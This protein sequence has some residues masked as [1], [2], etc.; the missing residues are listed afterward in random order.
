MSSFFI[1]TYVL[2]NKYV[3]GDDMSKTTIKIEGRTIDWSVCLF[4]GRSDGALVSR[5]LLRR[6]VGQS[7]GLSLIHASAGRPAG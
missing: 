3:Y 5:R 7:V 6:S 4:V 1:L 2:Y